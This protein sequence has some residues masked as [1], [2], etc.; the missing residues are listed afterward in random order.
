MAAVVLN[1]QE[2]C[3]FTLG[4]KMTILVIAE[5]HSVSAVLEQNRGHFSRFLKYQATLAEQDDVSIV[6]LGSNGDFVCQ[7]DRSKAC[8]WITIT[9]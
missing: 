5:T 6:L 2:A 3:K 4:Q 8:W 1:I 7:L 9:G